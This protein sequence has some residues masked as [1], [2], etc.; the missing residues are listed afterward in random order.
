MLNIGLNIKRAPSVLIFSTRMK[1]IFRNENDLGFFYLIRYLNT[2]YVKKRQT[3]ELDNSYAPFECNND[4]ND[5]PLV[6]IGEVIYC[7][8]FI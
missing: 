5:P 1:E 7:L 8:I 3:N 6:E 2:H 4:N